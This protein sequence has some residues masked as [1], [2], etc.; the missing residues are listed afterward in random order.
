MR[1]LQKA[2]AVARK[3][4]RQ[5]GRDRRTLLILLLVPA[6]FLLLYGYALSFD[7]Q[8]VS[9]A[10]QDN[11]RSPT[12]NRPPCTHRQETVDDRLGRSS[13]R[14]LVQRREP[15]A[16]SG[17]TGI[18][19]IATSGDDP[20]YPCP[21]VVASGIGQVVPNAVGSATGAHVAVPGVHRRVLL[22]GL[23]S[24]QPPHMDSV[25]GESDR[26][27]QPEQRP[28]ERPGRRV[29]SGSRRRW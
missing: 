17:T 26:T 13:V 2:L 21:V 11:D 7:V 25:R 28:T 1:P 12:S 16:A 23:A 9:L 3:E 15:R 8:N 22:N 14:G 27:R 18:H 24:L 29:R 10:V 6:F 4:L 5:I 20:E 19:A